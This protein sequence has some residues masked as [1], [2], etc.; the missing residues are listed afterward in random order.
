MAK[1]SGGSGSSRARDQT[2]PPP[3]ARS[4]GGAQERAQAAMGLAPTEPPQPP[5]WSKLAGWIEQHPRCRFLL[6]TAAWCGSVACCYMLKPGYKV[7]CA[8]YTAAV[9]GM[10]IHR[11]CCYEVKDCVLFILDL[12]FVNA[13]VLIVNFWFPGLVPKETWSLCAMLAQGPISGVTFSLQSASKLH[14]PSGF[15]NLLSHALPLWMAY[16]LRWESTMSEAPGVLD[17]VSQ[18]LLKVFIPWLVAYMAVAKLLVHGEV[19]RDGMLKEIY[20][21]WDTDKDGTLSFDEVLPHYLEASNHKDLTEQSV[22][23]AFAKFMEKEGLAPD[24]PMNMKVF[25]DWLKSMSHKGVV[26]WYEKTVDEGKRKTLAL[27]EGETERWRLIHKAV[28][29]VFG[30]VAGAIASQHPKVQLLW[31]GIVTL[32]LLWSGKSFFLG[33]STEKN[34]DFAG[35]RPFGQIRKIILDRAVWKVFEIPLSFTAITFELLT[36][37]ETKKALA[38]LFVLTA[39]YYIIAHPQDIPATL[40]GIYALLQTGLVP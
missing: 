31:F 36:T 7:L 11:V 20:K 6:W 33:G 9:L 37:R 2:P 35:I 30:I 8:A 28:L 16:T 29:H 21:V 38:I 32:S 34:E 4:S 18:T 25:C 12:V 15:E 26:R 27:Q 13:V 19:S 24:A 22:R 10:L 3:S 14:H 5:L 40:M 23:R 17:L 1:A 39:A